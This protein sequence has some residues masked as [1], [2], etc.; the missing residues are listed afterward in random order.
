MG[1]MGSLL[2]DLVRANASLKTVLRAH[3]RC[4]G[5]HEPLYGRLIGELRIL[6]DEA[7]RHVI[8]WQSIVS[9]HLYR[10][11]VPEM[12][13][14]AVCRMENDLLFATWIGLLHYYLV[15]NELFASGETVIG[16]LGEKLLKHFITLISPHF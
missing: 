8:V 16:S 4:I 13:S 1:E 2:H 5:E 7:K 15:N 10:A 9:H 11:A 14:G 12:R 6:P 3:M